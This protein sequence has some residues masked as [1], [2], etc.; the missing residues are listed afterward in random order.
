MTEN[1]RRVDEPHKPTVVRFTDDAT[2]NRNQI[3]KLNTQLGGEFPGREFAVSHSVA[4][5][6]V[7][8]RLSLAPNSVDPEH[9]NFE[10]GKQDFLLNEDIDI[11]TIANEIRPTL[12]QLFQREM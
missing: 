7:Q 11:T 3:D 2:E 8:L 1:T 12:E 4:D 5:G 9:S 6:R 10:L